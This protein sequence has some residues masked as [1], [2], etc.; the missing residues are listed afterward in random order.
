MRFPD[1]PQPVPP[2]AVSRHPSC[3][4]ALVGA[5]TVLLA[6]SASAQEVLRPAIADA[7]PGTPG[8]GGAVRVTTSPYLGGGDELWDVVPLYLYEDHRFHFDG[9]SGGVRLVNGD[10]LRLE[11]FA[12]YRF[13]RFDPDQPALA[14]LEAREQTVEAGMRATLSGRWGELEGLWVADTLGEHDGQQQEFTWRHRLDFGRWTVTPWISVERLGREVASYYFGVSDR[15]ASAS[16]F[17]AYGIDSA[18]NTSLGLNTAFELTPKMH[19]F[20]NVGTTNLDAAISASPI[21]ATDSFATAYLGLAYM[22]GAEDAPRAP[23]PAERSG[24]WSWRINGGYQAEG[25]IVGEISTG[26]FAGSTDASTHIA[27]LTASR[28]VMSGR[29]LD[30]LGKLAVFR[31]FE[32]GFQDNFFSYSAYV[33]ARFKGYSAVAQRESFRF[34]F[35]YGLNYAAKVP[36]V[37]QIKQDRRGRETNHLLNYLELSVDFPMRNFFAARFMQ[38]C[39]VGVSLVHRSGIFAISDILG[40]VSGGSDWITGHL[41]CT[42]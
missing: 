40:S 4:L 13:T 3:R 10:R 31:H 8:L 1:E 35:G 30:F 15:E 5:L 7:P 14:G 21:V 41:E 22:F 28:L 32:D 18:I 39:Y 27:G 19:L 29:R 17:D 24:E 38:D 23:V 33:M 25:N 12:R 11:A 36:I 6:G 34:G 16:A 20:G 26:S 37:E 2:V 9:T 42:R